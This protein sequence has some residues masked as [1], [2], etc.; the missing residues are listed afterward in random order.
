MYFYILSDNFTSPYNE[1]KPLLTDISPSRINNITYTKFNQEE[2][3]KKKIL[4]ENMKKLKKMRNYTVK[5]KKLH[6]FNFLFKE[7]SLTQ[8]NSKRKFVPMFDFKRVK[9]HK[10]E[11]KS[12]KKTETKH[13]KKKSSTRQSLENFFLTDLTSAS[14]KEMYPDAISI[15]KENNPNKIKLE[16]GRLRE[17]LKPVKKKVILAPVKTTL[18]KIYK[19]DNDLEGKI[20]EVIMN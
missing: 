16:I 7:L 1:I 12:L 17:G 13:F 2:F 20:K 5:V 10:K 6:N 19:T 3:Q 11:N 4:E 15:S 18:E 8:R 14:L 9:H